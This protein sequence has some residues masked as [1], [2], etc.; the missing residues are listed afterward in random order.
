MTN[1]HQRFAGL[2]LLSISCT[3]EPLDLPQPTVADYEEVASAI[4]RDLILEALSCQAEPPSYV[5][6][7][8]GPRGGL[9]LWARC[10]SGGFISYRAGVGPA[11]LDASRSRAWRLGSDFMGGFG[12]DGVGAMP[13]AFRSNEPAI[14]ARARVVFARHRL[15]FSQRFAL[16]EPSDH[17]ESLGQEITSRRET[18][19][20]FLAR[21]AGVGRAGP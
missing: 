21:G 10:R 18:V 16:L 11:L 12:R 9:A 14:R 7:M 3:A 1:G 15:Q 4:A 17:D 8:F 20:A 13:A 6:T 19:D 2:L 5:D